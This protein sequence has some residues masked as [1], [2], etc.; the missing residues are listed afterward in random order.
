MS[1]QIY[2]KE[3][4]KKEYFFLKRIDI[5]IINIL[6]HVNDGLMDR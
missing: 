3:N 4:E 5:P 2:R 6:V 1:I